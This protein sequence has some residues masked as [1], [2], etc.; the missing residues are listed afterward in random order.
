MNN[1][2]ISRR[3]LDGMLLVVPDFINPDQR[4]KGWN[5]CITYIQKNAP[6]V[7]AEPVRHGRWIMRG[8]RFRCSECD[9][10]ALQKDEGG[11][12][13]FSHE[14][15]YVKSSYCPNCGAKMDAEVK[16]ETLDPEPS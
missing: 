14:Y 11:T 16:H 10:V 2:L 9:A 8:G 4:T 12:G 3:K 1:D 5:E 15:V 13:G 6:A 7:D